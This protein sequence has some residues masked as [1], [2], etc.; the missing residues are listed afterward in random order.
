LFSDALAIYMGLFLNSHLL[1]PYA[2]PGKGDKEILAFLNDKKGDYALFSPETSDCA[3]RRYPNIVNFHEQNI[4]KR[5]YQA[6]VSKIGW[7]YNGR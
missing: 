1:V 3:D 7:Y 6:L 5:A 2:M 4:I